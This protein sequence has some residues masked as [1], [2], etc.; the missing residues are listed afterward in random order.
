[1]ATV[2]VAAAAGPGPATDA[3]PALPR[4]RSLPRRPH[5]AG[6]KPPR[7]PRH[8]PLCDPRTGTRRVRRPRALVQHAGG[9]SDAV[10]SGGPRVRRPRAGARRR[11]ARSRRRPRRAQ[12]AQAR[13]DREAAR[14]GVPRARGQAL[15]DR[16]RSP[17]GPRASH[18]SLADRN[19]HH[20]VPPRYGR[21]AHPPH[22]GFRG[23]VRRVRGELRRAGHRPS[24][25]TPSA[26]GCQRG[27]AHPPGLVLRH[28]HSGKRTGG[29][30]VPHDRPGP[31]ARRG[32][33]GLRPR[34]GSRARRRAA[35]V[36]ARAPRPLSSEHRARRLSGPARGPRHGRRARPRLQRRDPVPP[37]GAS[38]FASV[39][40]GGSG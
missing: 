25:D 27:A 20:D 19:G 2:A 36:H 14:G 21:P 40:S 15:A 12:P 3:H 24:F 7:G 13:R 28:P 29:H 23:A 8:S 35:L 9:G 26:Q 5:P 39:P 33:A 30:P 32:G 37:V 11:A 22:G 6:A 10:E 1:M 16:P 34:E 17:S 38:P 18:R 31:V 4:T